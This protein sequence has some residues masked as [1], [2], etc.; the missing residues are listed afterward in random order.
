ME[1]NEQ[2]NL[3]SADLESAGHALY[4]N[5]WQSKLAHAL[6]IDPRRIRQWMAGERKPAP[7]ITQDV[8]ALLET[9]K[10]ELAATLRKLKRKYGAN[11]VNR[12]DE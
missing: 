4:G 5:E 3:E 6:G 1:L 12:N 9:N 2:M 11:N 8:I 10:V 7:G